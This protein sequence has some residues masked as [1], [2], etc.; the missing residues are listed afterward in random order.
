[1]AVV[2]RA[3]FQLDSERP[4]VF[5]TEPTNAGLAVLTRRLGIPFRAIRDW[6]RAEQLS[7]ESLALLTAVIHILDVD[8]QRQER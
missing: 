4:C 6:G 5:Y 1:M 7:D 8:R 3:W 2:V